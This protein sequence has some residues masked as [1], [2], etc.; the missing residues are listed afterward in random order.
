MTNAVRRLCLALTELADDATCMQADSVPWQS[1]DLVG[2]RHRIRLC[3]NGPDAIAN[4]ERL[5]RTLPDHEFAISGILVAD[6]AVTDVNRSH[7]LSTIGLEALT[8]NDFVSADPTP[9]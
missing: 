8:L 7:E 1:A 2:E 9:G 4:A 6:I 3:L 5:A